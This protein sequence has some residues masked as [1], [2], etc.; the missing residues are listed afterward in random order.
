MHNLRT[1]IEEAYEVRK[2]GKKK[3]EIY[4]RYKGRRQK[5]EINIG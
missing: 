2:V 1:A 3:Y 5:S 4:T